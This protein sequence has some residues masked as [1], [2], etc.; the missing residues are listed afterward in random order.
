M[1]EKKGRLGEKER[2][3]WNNYL[4]YDETEKGAK[5]RNSRGKRKPMEMEGGKEKEMKRK[6]EKEIYF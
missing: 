6:Y 4:Q 2:E 5:A 1:F 3:E